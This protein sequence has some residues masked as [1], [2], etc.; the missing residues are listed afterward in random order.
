MPTVL[1]V[2]FWMAMAVAAFT[3]CI[4]IFGKTD[5]DLYL[6]KEDIARLSKKR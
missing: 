5:Q 2:I 1:E 3:I 6:S 4:L